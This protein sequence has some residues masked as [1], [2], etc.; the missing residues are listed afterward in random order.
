MSYPPQGSTADVSTIE[1]DVSTIESAI[2]RQITFMDFWS[3]LD[4]NI[5]VDTTAGDEN[6]PNVVV[7]GLPSGLTLA[8]VIMMFKYSKRVDSSGSA[9]KTNAAQ[10]MSIDSDSGRGSVVTAINIP[11]DSF[12]TAANATEGGDVIIG[13]NDVKA[14]VTG[15]GTFYPTWELA[16]VDGDSLTFYDVQV[17]LRIYFT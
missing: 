10:V 8:R 11:D 16:D 17:G 2:A 7:A 4:D 12:H 13:D 9:N 1:A 6:L 5:A 14:E 3:D 15:N